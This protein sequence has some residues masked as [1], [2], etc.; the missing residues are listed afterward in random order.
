M[1]MMMDYIQV[2]YAIYIYTVI[3]HI[4]LLIGILH[5]KQKWWKFVN[6]ESS[7]LWLAL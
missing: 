3:L 7:T 2:L 5:S 6:K 4:Q 1:T